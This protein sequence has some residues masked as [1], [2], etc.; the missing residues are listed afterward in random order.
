MYYYYHSL[1]KLFR[2]NLVSKSGDFAS[3]RSYHVN[4]MF[5]CHSENLRKIDG[6]DFIFTEIK[7]SVKK[8]MTPN[9]AQYV[10]RLIDHVV[11]NTAAI[12]MP[13]GERLEMDLLSLSLREDYFDVPEMMP[14]EGRSK[15]KK[16]DP[17]R[18]SSSRGPPR[19]QP[20]QGAAKFFESLWNICKSS[21]DVNHKNLELQRDSRRRHSAL[22]RER[23]VTVQPDG[24]EMAE[25]PHINFEMPPISDEMFYSVDPAQ[26]MPPYPRNR[27]TR[28]D[29]PEENQSEASV[30]SSSADG[31]EDD[32]EE[33]AAQRRREDD[34][35]LG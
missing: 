20:K 22:M 7:R 16:P 14:S 5:Y 3:V 23:G 27:T 13:R 34:I 6:C 8:R 12:G 17:M 26:F 18:A 10:Q 11:P 25:I 9:Y 33:E 19:A 1:A 29:D 24:A 4:L 15:K 32:E 28:H 30:S 21:Y 2:E 31:D 35:L